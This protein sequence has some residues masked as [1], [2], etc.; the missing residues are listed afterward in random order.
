MELNVVQEGSA[1]FVACPY[2]LIG[3]DTPPLGPYPTR[4][5]ASRAQHEIS[6]SVT[7]NSD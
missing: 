5:L 3:L 4:E 7:G 1:F 2:D 6:A